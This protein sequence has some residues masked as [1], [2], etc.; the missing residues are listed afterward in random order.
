MTS[1]AALDELDLSLA[2][3]LAG[4]A[5]A[6]EVERRLAQAGFADVRF[7]HGFVFQHLLR[8]PLTVGALARAMGV[9]Q[10]RASKAASELEELGYVRR[11]VDPTDARVRRLVLAERG[12]NA[13][14]AAREARAAVTA[15]LRERLGAR[16]VSAAEL[17]L[18]G[19]LTELG[20]EDA[21]RARRVRLPR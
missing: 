8:E 5:M 19:V 2:A 21:V 13:V 17:V 18:R 14:A 9:T 3:M 6:E 7:S 15:E 16:R 1:H 20:A 10:Q 12:R 4:L 11:E